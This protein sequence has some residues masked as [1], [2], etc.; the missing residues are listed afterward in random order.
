MGPALVAF[1][2][3]Q[4]SAP[5]VLGLQGE[6]EFLGSW[7]ARID[8]P[9]AVLEPVLVF[10]LEANR[11]TGSLSTSEG[12]LPVTNIR[13]Q[14]RYLGFDVVIAG[15]RLRFT[16]MKVEGKYSGRWTLPDAGL[17]GPW[18][19]TPLLDARALAG[20]WRARLSGREAE[21]E[22]TLTFAAIGTKV[23]GDA[24]LGGVKAALSNVELAKGML[25]FE[26]EL[27]GHRVALDGVLRDGALVG[28]WQESGTDRAGA[29][30]AERGQSR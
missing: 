1:I 9:N 5:S 28:K 14:Q 3:L 20:A 24:A 7:A 12:T 19:A 23:Q 21:L 10:R 16:G 6:E 29:W 27:G 18:Q 11:P 13:F 30:R 17:E 26:L 22:L 4:V 8:G 2:I 25:S 15:L